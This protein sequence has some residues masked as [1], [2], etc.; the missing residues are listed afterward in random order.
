[1]TSLKRQD[2]SVCSDSWPAAVTTVVVSGIFFFIHPQPDRQSVFWKKVS[3]GFAL[4]PP[5]SWPSTGVCWNNV[6][7]CRYCRFLKKM[8]RLNFK[9][10]NAFNKPPPKNYALT[11]DKYDLWKQQWSKNVIP[12]VE[13][14]WQILLLFLLS[15]FGGK[16]HAHFVVEKIKPA[17]LA[18]TKA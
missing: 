12:L 16:S 17:G 14:S 6:L 3:W 7:F 9:D 11:A 5:K 4:T 13:L 2:I 1:M 15:Y 18:F 8:F 10:Q